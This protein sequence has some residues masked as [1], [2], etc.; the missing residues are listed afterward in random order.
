[1][2]LANR[3]SDISSRHY[4]KDAQ[5]RRRRH[6]EVAEIRFERFSSEC[7]P[8]ACSNS[9]PNLDQYSTRS[10]STNDGD[11]AS[12]TSSRYRFWTASVHAE[13]TTRQPAVVDVPLQAF[14]LSFSAR[15]FEWERAVIVLLTLVS[16]R[17]AI[18]THWL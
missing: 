2:S 11:L 14:M 3:Q 5:S 16:G 12:R 7:N 4:I 10:N 17:H 13:Y 6:G 18:A 8:Q 9:A 1:M 15:R